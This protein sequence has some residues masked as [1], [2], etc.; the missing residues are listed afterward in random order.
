MTEK[1]FEKYGK[2]LW[3]LTEKGFTIKMVNK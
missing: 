1:E 2:R 3:G